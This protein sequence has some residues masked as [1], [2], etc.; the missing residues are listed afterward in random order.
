VLCSLSNFTT[1]KCRNDFSKTVKR[2][3]ITVAYDHALFI[4]CMKKMSRN[5]GRDNKY[6]QLKAI[7][8]AIKQEF[9]L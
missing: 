4:F 9:F 8:Y 2:I 7:T 6:L 5:N 3:M 1:K